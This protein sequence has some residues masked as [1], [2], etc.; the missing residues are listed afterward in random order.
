MPVG[1]E[2]KKGDSFRYNENGN[3]PE[4]EEECGSATSDDDIE[5][6]YIRDTLNPAECICP[7][8]EN[9]P[10]GYIKE[11][12]RYVSDITKGCKETICTAEGEE[13][14]DGSGYVKID[15]NMYV[16]PSTVV[17]KLKSKDKLCQTAEYGRTWC[18]GSYHVATKAEMEKIYANKDK[19]SSTLWQKAMS[20][21]EE[22]HTCNKKSECVAYCPDSNDDYRGFNI[23]TGEIAWKTGSGNSIHDHQVTTFCVSNVE[24]PEDNCVC[25][26]NKKCGCPAMITWHAG[27]NLDLYQGSYVSGK[28]S[29]SSSDNTC[30]CKRV[31]NTTCCYSGKKIADDPLILDLNGDGIKLTDIQGGVM[32][33]MSGTGVKSLTSW[34]V[35]GNTD[36]A[37]LCLPDEK[38]QVNDIHQLFGDI[39]TDDVDVDNGFE[40]LASFDKNKDGVINKDDAIYPTL[41]LWID[42]NRNA[43]VDDG[44]LFTLEDKGV[45]EISLNYSE[46]GSKDAY[47]N[48]N[49]FVSTFKRI[50]EGVGE[51]VRKIVD[52]IFNVWDYLTGK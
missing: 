45:T 28:Y 21:I 7:L 15:E 25:T 39:K 26:D 27:D 6:K 24:V 10:D 36:D 13:W 51:V 48:E 52:V 44:E 49:A 14:Q 22:G 32:F 23:E 9:M 42:T 20:A 35:K 43:R 4:C 33:D 47:G 2:F 3:Y 38:G 16:K 17:A 18:F 5:V 34:T 11:G 29:C 30:Y 1:F 40:H 41:R 19:F 46:D 37:F 12:E 31:N 8:K 50:V